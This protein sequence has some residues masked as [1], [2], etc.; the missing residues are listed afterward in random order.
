MKAQMNLFYGMAS[1]A[2]IALS[3]LSMRG[4]ILLP[5][6][7]TDNMVVQRNATLT[8]AGTGKPLSTVTFIQSQL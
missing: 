2:L 7:F 6:I 1:V 4:E 5:S 8:V 3:S